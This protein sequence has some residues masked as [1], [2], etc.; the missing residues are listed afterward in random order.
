[1]NEPQPPVLPLPEGL[2]D[3]AAAQLLE[4]LYEFTRVF[5]SYY[6]GQ[7]HR[8]YARPDDNQ[9]SLLDDPPF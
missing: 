6:A 3:E 2:S 1:M 9:L 7:L 8:Y 5:E 4:Y